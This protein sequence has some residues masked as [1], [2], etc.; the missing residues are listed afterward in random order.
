MNPFLFF[1]VL[2]VDLM[3]SRF[4]CF[5]DIFINFSHMKTPMALTNEFFLRPVSRPSDVSNCPYNIVSQIG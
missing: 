4:V 3:F 1:F 2:I 5:A